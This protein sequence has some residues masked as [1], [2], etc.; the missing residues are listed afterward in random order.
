MCVCVCV[1]TCRCIS[2][3]SESVAR[4]LYMHVCMCMAYMHEL[5]HTCTRIMAYMHENYGI[6][7]RE[8]SSF[9]CIHRITTSMCIHTN[10]HIPWSWASSS[11]STVEIMPA[12]ISRSDVCMYACMY[13]WNHA[14]AH[15]QIRCMY[16]CKPLLMGTI[17]EQCW[18][19]RVLK[20]SVRAVFMQWCVYAFMLHMYVQRQHAC[21]GQHFHV[22]L[23]T[24]VTVCMYTQTMT[25]NALCVHV[26]YECVLS[27]TYIQVWVRIFVHVHVCMVT[28][29]IIPTYTHTYI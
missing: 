25:L 24:C 10:E 4:S 19:S 12:H 15:E 9:T 29:H 13:V 14:C 17:F 6:H 8:L 21:R 3:G 26:W 22:Y 20:M 7:A 27:D 1:C 16:A 11:I 5:W 18:C 2:P 28:F 23:I